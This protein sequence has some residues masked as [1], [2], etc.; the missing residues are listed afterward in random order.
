MSVIWRKIWSDLWGH[1]VRT[2]L[3]VLSIAAGVFALGAI[4]GMIDQLVPN[5]NRVHGTIS[6]ANITMYLQ[7][8]ITQDTADRLKNI[9]GVVGVEVL[10][11]MPIR[12]R[13]S[14]DQEWQP[15]A[16]TMR[17]DYEEQKFNLL[18]LKAGEWPHRNEIGVDMRA[19]D[20]LGLKFGDTVMFE[21]EGSDRALPVTGKIRHHF[22][23]SPDFG[24]DPRF[25]VD[26]Q[27]LE[28]FG[29]PDGEFNELLVR[30]EPYSEDLARAIASEIKD[31][32]GKEGVGV[33]VTYYSKPDEHWAKHFFDGLNL[34]L[35]LLAFVSL[36]MS[37]V[38]VYNTLS[39]LITEQTNQIGIMKAL[40]GSTGVII[41]VYL[42][43]VLVY[44]LLAL[45]VSLPLG[46]WVA[47]NASRY[48]LG[49][50]NIDHNTF[51]FS[52][53]ALAV[54][55]VAAVGVPLVA[56]L[57]PV[58]R[59]A[60]ITVREAIASYGLGGTFGSN[61]FDRLVERLGR[62]FLSAPNAMALSNLFRRKGRLGLTQL[63]LIT[64][65]TLFLMVMTLSNSI[66]LT[67][68]NE[69]ARRTYQS[70]I[71]FENNQRINRVVRLAESLPGV[72]KAELRFSQS[73]S[74]L[75]TG[76]RTKEAGVGAR[77]VGILE[78]SDMY[79]P[80]IVA[81]RW[82]QAGDDRAIV[83]N[84]ETAEENN[85]HVGDRV[86]LNLGELGDRSWQ[87]V[88]LY[89]TVAVVPMPDNIYAPQ[90]A[91]FR[92]TPKHN[93]GSQLL[94]RTVLQDAASVEAITK[95]LK[96]IFDGRNWDVEDSQTIHED[97]SFFDNFFAQYIPM[98]LA[99]AVIMAIV[100]GIGLMGALS[101]SV[102]ERTK[103]IGV[104]RAIGAKTPVIMAMLILE[105]V[106][107]GVIS[108]LVAVPLSFLLGQPLA[109]LMGQAMF[110]IA[111]DYQYHLTAMGIWLAMVVVISI[112]ASVMPARNATTISV[113]E[114]LAYA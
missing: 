10:N 37:V 81:G 12:Y 112:L 78:G 104:M 11:E 14:P 109:V 62:R 41:R 18:Q 65:G 114:S 54:Q 28:R 56:A 30:V 76:Q 100:G 16:L 24:D 9:E 44:G 20:S 97:R 43:G 6:P 74:L 107:Q 94:V 61:P 31:R 82:L 113:R 108:W 39:A 36:F 46:A 67:V 51:Q 52:P 32:L 35:Q 103:E 91:I 27:G 38:L 45:L 55:A 47:F 4:F 105:G 73:A 1:K 50:F 25:F 99:L 86:T 96:D 68:N 93:I 13:L 7:D 89:R 48:F 90:E 22:M 59:G 79:R 26:A 29:V 80:M 34:I 53:S 5:L 101:I 17:A 75:K 63:V 49:I 87:V 23:T 2:L 69:L 64:A 98:L 21:L 66:T 3:A 58:F 84:A 83:I 92:A 33:G 106:L 71:F 70:A 72:A 19:F 102:A 57:I 95:Q 85:I 77:L 15:G 8:R 110:D 60:L 111:L 88:G 40:G 42:A